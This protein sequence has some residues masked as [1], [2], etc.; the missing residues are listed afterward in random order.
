MIGSLFY[1]TASRPDIVHS[2]CLCAKYQSQPKETHL[3]AVK[4]IIRYVKHTSDYGLF[5]PKN[6]SFDSISY[7][8]VDYAGCKSDRKSTS[9]TCHFLGHSLVSWLSKKQNMVSLSTTEAEYISAAL[10]CSQVIYMQQTL[11]DYG[12]NISKSP[13][14][15]DN[16]SA[17]NLSKNTTHHARTKHIDIRHHFLRD[18]ISNEVITLDYIN[19]ENQIADILTKPLNE[20]IFT[21]LRRELGICSITEI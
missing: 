16:T 14:Y 17:I 12:L 3:K 20:S 15:C 19:S 4:L 5:Y 10:A 13:I 18:N 8:D 9:G 1:I 21:K 7:Y 6:D 2:V 11:K